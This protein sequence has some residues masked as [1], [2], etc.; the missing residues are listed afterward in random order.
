M[1]RKLTWQPHP[2]LKTLLSFGVMAEKSPKAR[3]IA[4]TLY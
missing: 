1:A 4:W 2:G 3:T